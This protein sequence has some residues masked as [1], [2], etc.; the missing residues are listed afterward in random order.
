M[1]VFRIVDLFNK[2]KHAWR[3]SLTNAEQFRLLF[4]CIFLRHAEV[5]R[6]GIPFEHMYQ[7]RSSSSGDNGVAIYLEKTVEALHDAIKF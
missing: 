1:G 2:M 7:Y 5:T 6:V 3:S 4:S